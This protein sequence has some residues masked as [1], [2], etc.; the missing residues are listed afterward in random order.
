MVTAAFLARL[1]KSVA[2]D[3]VAAQGIRGGKNVVITDMPN[4]VI[5]PALALVTMTIGYN[6]RES[7]ELSTQ[8]L[9]AWRNKDIN[10]YLNGVLVVSFP[11]LA[12]SVPAPGLP[13]SDTLPP[14]DGGGGTGGA[15]SVTGNTVY[16]ETPGGLINGLNRTYTL[17]RAPS[18]QGSLLLYRN[19]LLQKRGDD[20]VFSGPTRI[21]FNFLAPAVGDTLLASYTF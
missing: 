15:P 14:L 18:P 12:T 3:V 13:P 6:T 9:N 10:L 8:T 21:Q 5:I 7:V 4:Q 19:G 17:T 11:P 16:N 2:V 20:Y 1:E